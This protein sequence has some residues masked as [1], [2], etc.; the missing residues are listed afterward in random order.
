MRTLRLAVPLAAVLL[1]GLTVVAGD[2]PAA[3][4]PVQDLIDHFIDERLHDEGVTPAPPA[5]DATLVRRVTLDLAGR[6]PTAAEVKAFVASADPAKRVQLVDRLM[7]SPGFVRHQA[8]EF[9]A[10]LM[11]GYRASLRDYLS[12]AFTENKS[13]DRIFRDLL[14][15]DESDPDKKGAGEFLRLRVRDTDKLT[16]EVSALFFGVNVSCAQCHDHPLVSDWK[17]D[18]YYGMKSFF[19]RTFDNGG[20]VAEREIGLVKFQTTK[21]AGRD[22]K[23]MFLTGAVIDTPT[24]RE[25]TKEEAKRDKDHFDGF[26][27]R[28]A[29]PPPP[30]YSVRAQLVDLALRPD[31]RGFFAK[32][33]VNRLWHRFFGRG[34]VTP[35]DQ[36]HSENPPSHPELLD[37]LARDTAEHGYDLRRLI[38]GL[39]L[40]RAYARSSRWEGG[41]PPPPQLFAVARVR[42]LSPLQLATALRIAT[43][44][45]ASLTGLKPEEFEKRMESLG[46]RARSFAASLD[47]PSG[48]DVQIGVSESLL[49]SNGD[50]F[51]NEFLADGNDRLIGRLSA[52]ADPAQVVDM[53]VL[54]V[55][56]RPATDEERHLLGDYLARRADR[57]AEACRQMVWALL[58]GAEFRFNH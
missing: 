10:L 5:D 43:A 24:L 57:K 3:N 56:S 31:Q 39:V 58:A 18:H 38:R 15:P 37:A 11:A 46:A 28:K 54:A 51:R 13:W 47:L 48:D 35:L 19:A 40:S 2:P 12:R 9:D 16:T 55:L 42:P 23:L 8:A 45:P 6:I 44:D 4:R 36:M 7:A 27:Q 49:F 17:Q 25:P 41:D 20:F 14:V 32:A 29:A 34:L 52:I 30:A 50:K 53:A 1:A 22:A 21:G 26:K 33:I